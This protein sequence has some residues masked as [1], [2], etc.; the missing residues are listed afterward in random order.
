MLVLGRLAEVYR[1]V[2]WVIIPRAGG[3]SFVH[4]TQQIC[5]HNMEPALRNEA[6]EKK[7]REWKHF[8]DM[9][10]LLLMLVT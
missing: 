7:D 6:L 1:N 3:K 9:C 8:R 2:F 4:E 5:C 10:W